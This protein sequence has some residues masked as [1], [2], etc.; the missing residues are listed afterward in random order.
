MLRVIIFNVERGFCS[1]IRSPN[2]YAL[3]IDCGSSADFSPVKYIIDNEIKCVKEFQDC[4]LAEFVCSHPHD[5]HISNI[6]LLE[7]KLKPSVICS[8]RFSDWDEIKDPEEKKKDAYLNLDSYADF[9][10]SY[11]GK[12]TAYPDWGMMVNTD[13]GL[14]P[15][16]SKKV[17]SDGLAWVNNSS[18][19]VVVSYKGHKFFFP[20]DLMKDGWETLLKRESF[21]KAL[22]GTHFFIASHHGHPSGYTSEIFKTCKPWVNIVSEK[23]REK[24]EPAYSSEENASGVKIEKEVRRM[25]TTRKDGSIVIEIDKNGDWYYNTF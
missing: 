18:I 9:R 23:P 4:E 21:K 22:K 17:N 6:Q 12:V 16:E 8:W 25:L 2:N 13:L 3:L 7:K 11:T 19:I 10:D 5:D 20:G 24:I 14:T 1:F 15:S